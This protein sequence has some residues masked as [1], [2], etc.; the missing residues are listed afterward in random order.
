MSQV[1]QQHNRLLVRARAYSVALCL[2]LVAV[3][4]A[5]GCA[6]VGDVVVVEPLDRPEAAAP[7]ATAT[8][9]PAVPVATAL[10]TDS[11]RQPA[12]PTAIPT[13]TP[14]ATPELGFYPP[15]GREF[16]TL[17]DFWDGRAEWVLEIYDA[18]L[19]LGES[20][21]V[22]RG[23]YELWSYLHASYQSAGV[24]DR[25]GDPVEFPG[26]TT[27][28]KSYDAGRTFAME[29]SVCLF[30][31]AACPCDHRRDHIGQQQ[32][33][34]VI[35]GPDLAYLVYEFG[36]YNYL[37]TSSDGLDWSDYRH[38]PGTWIWTHPYG[39]CTGPAQIGEHPNIHRQFEWDCLVGGPPG[40]YLEGDQ[41]YVFVAMGKAPGHM[42]CFSGNRHEGAAG[43]RPCRNNPLFGAEMG[44]GPLELLGAAANP[45]FEFRTISSADVVRAGDR[46]Y[47]TYEGVR[48]P[49]S[50]EV[51]DDQF[52]LGLAR[53]TGF[54]IDGQWERYPGN[55]IIMDLP[56]NVGVGHADLI[57]IG[58][59]TYI[60]TTTSD[61]TRGRYVLLKKENS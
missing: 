54:E 33:P 12:T 5:A 42:G 9:D 52:A 51:V 6:Y 30:E 53:S 16:A 60:Y 20:D 45:Y 37:R 32:Y 49:S 28:W 43:L 41:L 40:I 15:P 34:R 56:G 4:L 48:G 35:F 44:Y 8:P 46:Y 55:P 47:M 27:L 22:Y 58:D 31:C 50:I 11:P 38:I 17:D 24:V 61:T 3:V 7:V 36:A 25:C 2:I 26:C 57:I 1:S 21:T 59:A 18:G 10:A 19:P 14:T 23:N 13:T 29:E 39:L